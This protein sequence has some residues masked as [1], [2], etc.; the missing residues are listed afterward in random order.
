MLTN[1]HHLAVYGPPGS[2]KTSLVQRAVSRG[3]LAQDLEEVGKTYTERRAFIAELGDVEPTMFGA[4]DLCPEDLPSGTRLVLLVPSATELVRRV[5]KRG[6]GRDHKWIEHALQVRRE[7]LQMADE[8]V[9]DLVIR[10]DASTDE[11]L[12]IIAR[13]FVGPSQ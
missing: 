11:I 1:S 8:G 6:D 9:F 2:G 7:H 12:D 10:V 4:A 5:R 3:Y 13:T